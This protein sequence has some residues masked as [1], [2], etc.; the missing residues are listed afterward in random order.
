MIMRRPN[1]LFCA[2]DPSGTVRLV[3]ALSKQLKNRVVVGRM[4]DWLSLLVH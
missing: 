2:F 3:Q 1:P 4:N